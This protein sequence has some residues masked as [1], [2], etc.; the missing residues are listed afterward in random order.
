MGNI[1]NKN[2]LRFVQFLCLTL[3]YSNI[4]SY[5]V[6]FLFV[7]ISARRFARALLFCVD[8]ENIP[9]FDSV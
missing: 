7:I 4:V 9:S 3:L 1:L 6:F 8:N 5:T 2:H